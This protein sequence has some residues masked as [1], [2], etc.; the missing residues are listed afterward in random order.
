LVVVIGHLLFGCSDTVPDEE[1]IKPAAARLRV[2][3]I[4]P[5]F[6]SDFLQFFLARRTK[7]ESP[8]LKDRT[9]TPPIA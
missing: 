9:T 5:R 7:P 3:A 4:T 1:M 8:A 2:T 6:F